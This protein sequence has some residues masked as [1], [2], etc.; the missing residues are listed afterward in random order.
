MGKTGID[1]FT[2]LAANVRSITTQTTTYTVLSTDEYVKGNGTFTATLPVISTLIGT[3]FSKKLYFLENISSAANAYILTVSA[4]SGNT[5]GGRSTI[6]LQPGEKMAISATETDTDWEILF[7][8]PMPPAVRNN[9]VVV[10]T[11]SDTTAVNAID[12]S[13]CPVVGQ[14][15]SVVSYAQNATAAN[16][17][18]KNANGTVCTIAKGTAAGGAVSATD[19]SAPTMAV[20]DLLTVESSATNGT[21]RVEIVISTQTLTANG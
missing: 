14:I 20:G 1:L 11:T 3:T 12:A 9:F 13:G 17:L 16:I 6:T 8:S 4:G 5:I 10:A 15:V 21:S 18:V 2:S 19:L 7:P